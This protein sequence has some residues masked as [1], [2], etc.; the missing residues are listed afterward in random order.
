MKKFQ[1][2]YY[3]FVTAGLALV[4]SFTFFAWKFFPWLPLLFS[5]TSSTPSCGCA[6]ASLMQ[7]TIW[8][9]SLF[10]GIGVLGGVY[11]SF[12]LAGAMAEIRRTSRFLRQLQISSHFFYREKK[13]L[14]FTASNTHCF[15]AGWFF[16]SIYLSSALRQTLTR[17]EL[18]VVLEHEVHHARHRDPLKRLTL[19][20]MLFPLR[21]LAISRMLQAVIELH[22]EHRAD[23]FALRRH[24]RTLFLRAWSKC[25]DATPTLPSAVAAFRI[26]EARLQLLLHEPLSFQFSP[27]LI[28]FGLALAFWSGTHLVLATQGPI[29]PMTLLPQD[30]QTSNILMCLQQW[31]ERKRGPMSQDAIQCPNLNPLSK[32]IPSSH[33]NVDNSY[34]T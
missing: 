11:F 17:E 3:F 13:I 25:V 16:P 31:R 26:E 1:L 15:T 14:V 4:G 8:G 33:S 18:N 19:H 5:G 22:H 7:P 34:G 2:T 29:V 9:W 30:S 10:L 32:P 20:A 21:K 24:S 23:H 12:V 28:F 27:S 6:G